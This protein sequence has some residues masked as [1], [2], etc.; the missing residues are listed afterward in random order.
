MGLRDL[1]GVR[2][3]DKGKHDTASG[4]AVLE[5][6]STASTANLD[7]ETLEVP[8]FGAPA[9]GVILPKRGASGAYNPY[10]GLGGPFDP[11]MNKA[12]YSLTD[13]PEF[14]F[15]EERT[16]R[17]R[18]WS[19]NLTYLTGVGYLGG[20]IAGGGWG[21]YGSMKAAPDAALETSKLRLNRMLNSVSSRGRS[22]GNTWG[23][24]G[25]YYAA[26]E[27]ASM[28]YTEN[29][30]DTLCSIFAGGGAGALYKSMS[31]PRAIAVYG[32]GGALLSGLNV[33]VQSAI[34]R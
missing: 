11:S 26:L 1:L 9:E 18:S 29:R 20:S 14:L 10:S 30:Y 22:I 3:G 27:S 33:A 21:L 16:M 34:G 5:E 6:Q 31:G 25:L 17:T 7:R 28:A 24:I 13:A 2:R 15:D 12:L 32:A 19:E 23:C 8:N 4:V